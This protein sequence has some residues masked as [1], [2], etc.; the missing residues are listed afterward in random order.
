MR[1]KLSKSY[2]GRHNGQEI[3]VEKLIGLSAMGKYPE[4]KNDITLKININFLFFF[5]TIKMTKIKNNVH[6][7]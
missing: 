2:D 1:L 3:P 4:A 7:Y 5:K 6:I